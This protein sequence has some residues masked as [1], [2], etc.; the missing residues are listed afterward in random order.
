MKTFL[1]SAQ[2]WSQGISN[3][4]G[5]NQGHG[6]VLMANMLRS[7]HAQVVGAEDTCFV[8]SVGWIA[9]DQPVHNAMENSPL[10]VVEDEEIDKLEI[11]LA[12]KTK[13][14]RIYASPPPEVSAKISRT[15]KNLNA[16]TGIFSKRM[17]KVHGDPILHAQRVEAMKRAKRTAAARQHIS[18]TLKVFFS[19]PE[20]R[21]KRSL[22]MK[23]ES[24][25]QKGESNQKGN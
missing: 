11:E 3:S 21:L 20:N 16:V 4:V 14:K 12:P 18:E 25:H 19:N 5:L 10:N 15:L 23:G 1:E 9:P 17:K 2:I 7:Y 6:L 22:S 24:K 8:Q 13:S